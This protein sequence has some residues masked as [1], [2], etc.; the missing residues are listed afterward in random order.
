VGWIYK[1]EA[2]P[3]QWAKVHSRFGTVMLDVMSAWSHPHPASSF[4]VTLSTAKVAVGYVGQGIWRLRRP[5]HDRPAWR[6][7]DYE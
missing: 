2:W 5:Q 4:T 6:A 1:E 3:T 7:S